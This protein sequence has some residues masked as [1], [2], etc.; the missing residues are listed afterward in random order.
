MQGQFNDSTTYFTGISSTGTYNQTNLN[1]T[2]LLN[3]GFRIGVKKKDVSLNASHK[4][5][6]GKQG[7]RI[8]NNDFSAVWDL[9]LYKTFKHFN[10]WALFV[11][12]TIYSLRVNNQ[13]QS[14]VGIAYNVID[15]QNSQLNVSDGI[16]YDYSDVQIQD[17]VRDVYETYR[18]SFRLQYKLN[19]KNFSF[20]SAFFLQN[21]LEYGSDY[22][23]KS[24]SSLSLKIR[25]W[26]SLT[27]QANYNHMSRTKKETVFITYGLSYERYF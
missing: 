13:L 24:E 4:W 21:S 5:L 7:G 23:V 12:N 10:Y 22:I 14:G 26:L 8:V 2:F 9:N 1:R 11:Y 6:Y 16:I 3:N 20:R 17:T 15:R 27:L 18:N 19:L 25:R